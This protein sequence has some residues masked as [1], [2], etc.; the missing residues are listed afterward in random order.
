[1]RDAYAEVF[2]TYWLRIASIKVL[3]IMAA[4]VPLFAILFIFLSAFWAD[5]AEHRRD[6]EP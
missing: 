4:L 6:K 5:G 1:M 2:R 3:Y